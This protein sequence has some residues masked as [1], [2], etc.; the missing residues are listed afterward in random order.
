MKIHYT[1]TNYEIKIMKYIAVIIKLW[2]KI[3]SYV[4]TTSPNYE[5]DMSQNY[6]IKV[7]IVIKYNIC[8]KW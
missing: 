2:H 8:D 7:F 1:N 4:I 5:T 6:H 3:K